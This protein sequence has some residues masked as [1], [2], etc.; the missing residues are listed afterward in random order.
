MVRQV[1]NCAPTNHHTLPNS[2]QSWPNLEGLGR[3]FH[4]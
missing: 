4:H 1:Y 3:F 2:L